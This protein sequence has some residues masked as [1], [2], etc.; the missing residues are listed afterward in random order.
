[1]VNILSVKVYGIVYFTVLR[2]N[3]KIVNVCAKT[4]AELERRKLGSNV[5]GVRERD[6]NFAPFGKQLNVT[7]VPEIVNLNSS[8]RKL[9]DLVTDQFNVRPTCSVEA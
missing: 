4:V 6:M 2:K 9:G 5:I 8:L 7:V 1:M 3:W